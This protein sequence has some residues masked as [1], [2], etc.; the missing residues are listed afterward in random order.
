ME[1]VEGNSFL[2][3]WPMGLSHSRLF[4]LGH[5]LYLTDSLGD[6]YCWEV[7]FV[8]LIFDIVTMLSLPRCRCSDGVVP[9]KLATA[10]TMS[11]QAKSSPKRM[12]FA[13]CKV[14]HY[15]TRQMY[16]CCMYALICFLTVLLLGSSS[17]PKRVVQRHEHGTSFVHHD[18]HC[19]QE[20]D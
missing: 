2:S 14:V 9:T 13:S 12:V 15:S 18:N 16:C 4:S 17:Q 10:S 7:F 11:K 6:Y 19:E 20:V 1:T 5:L 3:G 8:D